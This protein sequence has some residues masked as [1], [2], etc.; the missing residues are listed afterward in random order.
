MIGGLA[1]RDQGDWDYLHGLRAP[2]PDPG[3]IGPFAG[4]NPVVS[5][6]GSA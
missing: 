4:L 2:L 3:W 1:R 6:Q 5:R